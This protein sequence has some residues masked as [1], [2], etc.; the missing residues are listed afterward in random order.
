VNVMCCQV[1]VSATIPIPRTEGSYR[2][3]VAGCDQL[4]Q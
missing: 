3:C 2:V 1:E 4:Q